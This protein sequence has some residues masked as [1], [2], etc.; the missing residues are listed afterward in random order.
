MTYNKPE[1]AKLDSAVSVIQGSGPKGINQY[2]DALRPH[3][4][5]AMTVGAYEADE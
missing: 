1:V 4:S 3:N 5:D 2:T